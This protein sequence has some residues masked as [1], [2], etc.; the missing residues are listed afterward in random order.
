[1][2]KENFQKT[3]PGA[4][5][6][7]KGMATQLAEGSLNSGAHVQMEGEDGFHKAV[8]S[9]CHMSLVYCSC[10]FLSAHTCWPVRTHTQK[11][12]KINKNHKIN[13][14][15]A[16]LPCAPLVPSGISTGCSRVCLLSL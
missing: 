9:D 14:G 4:R 5:E 2:R 12:L 11:F 15:T 3:N 6:L 13:L 1:M 16:W 7:G 8:A 10:T